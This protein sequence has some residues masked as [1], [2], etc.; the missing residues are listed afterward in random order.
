MALFGAFV[1]KIGFDLLFP[2]RAG[3]GEAFVNEGMILIALGL[4]IAIGSDILYRILDQRRG[5][6][7]FVIVLAAIGWVQG[8]AFAFGE[9]QPNLFF[10]A[11][12]GPILSIFGGVLAMQSP[13][14]E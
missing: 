10:A 12:V 11:S 14:P 4:L 3:P 1:T 8:A 9:G 7:A 5:W 13:S 2:V 6:A